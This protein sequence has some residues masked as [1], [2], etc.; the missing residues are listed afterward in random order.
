MIFNIDMTEPQLCQ[1]LIQ[2]TGAGTLP[3]RSMYP[4]GLNGRYRCKL[5]GVAF[6]DQTNAKDNRIIYIRS[7]SFRK[8]YGTN[9]AIL[10]SNRHEHS[11]LGGQQGEYPFYLETNGGGI[12]ITLE[13]STAYT[14]GA[15]DT[16]NYCILS[17]SVEPIE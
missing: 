11:N 12:D 2:A 1:I 10:I 9:N 7:D 3:S 5:I 4:V 13:A 6:A 16:F 14:G 8:A 17:L 15:N